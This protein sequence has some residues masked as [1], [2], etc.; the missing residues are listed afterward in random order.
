MGEARLEAPVPALPRCWPKKLTVL[1]VGWICA[2]EEGPDEA[3]TLDDDA[4]GGGL[5]DIVQPNQGS[6]M[7]RCATMTM[8]PEAIA[9]AVVTSMESEGGVARG[10]TERKGSDMGVAVV[11]WGAVT[12]HPVPGEEQ[13]EVAD[14]TITQMTTGNHVMGADAAGAAV[15]AS[16]LNSC[17]RR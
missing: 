5:E 13:S 16:F 1:S 14:D 4:T 2:G 17:D 11:V 7:G 15:V 12:G 3:D 8:T 9:G 10:M 6:T